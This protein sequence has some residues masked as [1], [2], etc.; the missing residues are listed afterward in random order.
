MRTTC[1]AAWTAGSA[2]SVRWMIHG[3][4][5]TTWRAG[6]VPCAMHRLTTVALTPNCWAACLRVSQSCPCAKFGSRYGERT[7]A[8]RC[9]RQVLPVPVREPK[10]LSVAAMVRAR[11]TLVSSA[12]TPMTSCSVARP[13]LPGALRATRHSVCTPPCQCRRKRYS[14]GADV[15]SILISYSTVRR[16][17]FVS[18]S[19]AAA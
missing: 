7:H 4:W 11:W 2:T 15:L 9:A 19:G 6:K 3:A 13:C 1:T 18:A 8:T 5:G 16:R 12:I 10:R 17:R 14:D